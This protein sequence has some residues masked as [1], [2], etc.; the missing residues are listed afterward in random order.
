M[1]TQPVD[2]LEQQATEQRQQ[3]HAT[4]AEL[5][6]KISEAKEKL[7]VTR[8]LREHLFAVCV[9]IGAAA[10]LVSTIVASRFKR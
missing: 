6:R 2:N 7:N 9:G 8:N 3:I 4:A 5:K 1:S 10:L